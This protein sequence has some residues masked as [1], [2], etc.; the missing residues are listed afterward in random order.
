MANNNDGTPDRTSDESL[1]VEVLSNATGLPQLRG[2][3]KEI[4]TVRRNCFDESYLRFLDEQI[5]LAVRGPEWTERLRK[6]RAGLEDY[7]GVTLLD[8]FI[9]VG[10]SDFLIYVDPETQTI[11]YCEEFQDSHGS[12]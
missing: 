2:Q 6:R 3:P 9:R 11:V 10:A 4:L 7:C 12:A 5:Q 8:A 1:F